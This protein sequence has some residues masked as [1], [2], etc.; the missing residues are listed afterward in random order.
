MWSSPDW[1]KEMDMVFA[2]IDRVL[3]PGGSIVLLETLGTGT[4]EPNR[5]G[6]WYHDYLRENWFRMEWFRTDYLFESVDEAFMLA[7]FFWGKGVAEGIRKKGEL[8]L[9]ECTALWQRKKEL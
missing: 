4:A 1:K 7:R 9:Q 2:Q 6:G 8:R 5:L 3:K